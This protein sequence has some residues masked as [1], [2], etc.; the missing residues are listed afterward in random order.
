MYPSGLTLNQDQ[1]QVISEHHPYYFL[2][3]EKSSI[4]PI[5]IIT[6]RLLNPP[7]QD[8]GRAMLMLRLMTLTSKRLVI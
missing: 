5:I 6:D 1:L 7:L 2:L 8:G 3:L 4:K